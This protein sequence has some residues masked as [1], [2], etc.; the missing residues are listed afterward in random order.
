S[1]R[2]PAF[3]SMCGSFFGL[4]TFVLARLGVSWTEEI[5]GWSLTLG[6]GIAGA[7]MIL[8]VLM[9]L[10][11]GVRPLMNEISITLK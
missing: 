10:F 3:F 1:R 6:T 4:T 2:V 11:K 9:L 7:V 5:Y 8:L